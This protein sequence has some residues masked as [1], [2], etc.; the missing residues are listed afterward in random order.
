MKVMYFDQISIVVESVFVV[1]SV[2]TNSSLVGAFQDSKVA[3]S[4]W[5]SPSVSRDRVVDSRY[6]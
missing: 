6:W 4:K 1:V 2:V 5:A 3:G